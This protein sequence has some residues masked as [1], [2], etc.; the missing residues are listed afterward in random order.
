MEAENFVAATTTVLEMPLKEILHLG[1]Q[2]PADQF[3][4]KE[5]QEQ[6]RANHTVRDFH[7]DSVLHT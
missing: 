1:T 7:T 3:I 4:V 2:T 6:F 5:V